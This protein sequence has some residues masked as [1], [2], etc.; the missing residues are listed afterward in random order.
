[1]REE[2][3]VAIPIKVTDNFS[4]EQDTS[5]LHQLLAQELNGKS[6]E[7]KTL[8]L[9]VAKKLMIQKPEDCLCNHLHKLIENR[10]K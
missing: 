6:C 3:K 4:S 10:G 8:S 2:Q 5:D 9:P 1:M 7:I